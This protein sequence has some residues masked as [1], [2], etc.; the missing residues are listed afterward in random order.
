[1]LNIFTNDPVHAIKESRL[2]NYAD[3]PKLHSSHQDSDIVVAEIS[4]H[5]DRA[6]PWFTRNGMKVNPTKHQAM[7][8]GNCKLEIQTTLDGTKVPVINHV[9]LL[10][11]T[12]DNKLKFDMHI[13]GVCREVD[14]QINVLNRL[15]NI[16]PLEVKEALYH[17][18]GIIVVREM[19]ENWRKL[20]RQHYVTDL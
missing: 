8:L 1:M 10:G 2:T 5:L 15:K 11:M 12:I 17:S 18:S 7:V 9:V 4:K 13:V 19:C 6:N 3:D 16:Q 14:R 20:K